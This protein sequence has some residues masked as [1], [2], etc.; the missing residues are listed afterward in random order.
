M[1]GVN[2]GPFR[3]NF[4]Y[5]AD[6]H[7]PISLSIASLSNLRPPRFPHKLL[8]FYSTKIIPTDIIN[9]LYFLADI[10]VME[11]FTFPSTPL[12]ILLAVGNDTAAATAHIQPA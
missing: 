12:T 6:N 10:P 2:N 11:A 5:T 4:E 3:C 7:I 8:V 1:P 9:L